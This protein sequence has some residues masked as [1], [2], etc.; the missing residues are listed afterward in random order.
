MIRHTVAEPR[1]SFL[2]TL[3]LVIGIVIGINAAVH[4]LNLLPGSYGGV[5]GFFLILALAIYTSRLMNRK[6]ASY[7]YEWDG[8]KLMIQKRL[9]R[10]D[11]T[12]LELPKENIQWIRSMEEIKH[13]LGTMKPPKKTLS[14]SCRM[15]GQ[16]VRVLQYQDGKKPYRVIMEP[17]EKLYKELKKAAKENGKG[18]S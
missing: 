11:K 13:S 4:L 7:T 9:G 8:K 18:D 14:L 3:L 2:T 6:L 17:G 16:G 5:G 1:K 10:R 15:R 12:M